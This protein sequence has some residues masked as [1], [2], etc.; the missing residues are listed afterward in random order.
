ML[1][2]DLG[3]SKAE[4]RWTIPGAG[5]RTVISVVFTFAFVFV[6]GFV[7][8]INADADPAAVVFLSL[9]P[10]SLQ[11]RGVWQASLFP[12]VAR[13]EVPASSRY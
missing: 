5:S 1:T 13:D 10:P 4:S 2:V 11:V 3:I 12:N 9:S 7:A 8:A 6:F